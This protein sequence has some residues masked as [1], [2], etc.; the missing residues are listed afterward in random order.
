MRVE[1]ER[2]SEWTGC[3]EYYHPAQWEGER[4]AEWVCAITSLEH[5]NVKSIN[6]NL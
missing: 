2:E 3:Q 1:R 5:D 4:R 6:M